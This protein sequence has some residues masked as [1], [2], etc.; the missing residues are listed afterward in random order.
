[1]GLNDEALAVSDDVVSRYADTGEPI[2]DKQVAI[3]LDRKGDILAQL[4]RTNEARAAYD[5]ILDRFK[6]AT[7]PEIQKLVASAR[8]QSAEV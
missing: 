4:G 7:D 3:A 2:L 6:S 5:E 1:V 8:T